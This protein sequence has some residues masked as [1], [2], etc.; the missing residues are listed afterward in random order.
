MTRTLLF[1]VTAST[2]AGC[3]PTYEPQ[4]PDLQIVS[5]RKIGGTVSTALCELEDRC[6]R[7]GPGHEH[8]TVASCAVAHARDAG[9][10]VDAE[11]CQDGAWQSRLEEC[12]SAI[13][14]ASCSD[15]AVDPGSL[16]AC[17]EDRMC[18]QSDADASVS[19]TSHGRIG[20]AE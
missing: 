1:L 3:T 6:G 4:P 16:L 15:E 14:V 20:S 18:L 17:D 12:V 7:I 8:A 5:Q 2:F 19:A 13:L 9:D 10:D 11:D